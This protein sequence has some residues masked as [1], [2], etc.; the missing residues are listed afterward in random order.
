MMRATGSDNGPAVDPEPGTAPSPRAYRILLVDDDADFRESLQMLLEQ[1][2]HQVKAVGNGAKAV[3]LF[4]VLK[5]ETDLIL[6]DYFMP[7]MNGEETLCHLRRLKPDVKV[8]LLS[9]ADELRIRR[10]FADH[11]LN[12]Y[13]RKPFVNQEMLDVFRRVGA[14][15]T[16]AH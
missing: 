15:P 11:A 8:V 10:V 16:P 6:L 14:E 3:R 4:G 7:G 2:G 5:D 12:A 9:G 1:L 13:L